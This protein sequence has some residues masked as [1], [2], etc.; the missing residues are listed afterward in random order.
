MIVMPGVI[1][2]L[3]LWCLMYKAYLRHQLA[4]LREFPGARQIAV[5]IHSHL[6]S[7]NGYQM[8]FSA[9]IKPL[10]PSFNVCHPTRIE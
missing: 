9:Y 2:L 4:C 5:H 8:T 7:R 1:D 10:E 6:R 3:R